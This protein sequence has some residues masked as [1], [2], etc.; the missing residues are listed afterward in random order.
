[1]QHSVGTPHVLKFP[2]LAC[3]CCLKLGPTFKLRGGAG[4]LL[5]TLYN[6]LSCACLQLQQQP[7]PPEAK[8]VPHTGPTDYIVRLSS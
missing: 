1:M 5:S 6:L 7:H 3:T 4:P 8:A 2:S